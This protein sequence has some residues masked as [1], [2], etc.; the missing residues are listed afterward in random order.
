MHFVDIIYILF[1]KILI[2]HFC[3]YIFV[4]AHHALKT[5]KMKPLYYQMLN[6]SFRKFQ[7]TNLIEILP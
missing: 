2:L 7:P 6:F 4:Y 5:R 1:N 3:L